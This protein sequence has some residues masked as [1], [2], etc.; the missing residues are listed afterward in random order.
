MF[1]IRPPLFIG[2]SVDHIAAKKIIG[3]AVK[4]LLGGDPKMCEASYG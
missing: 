3:L 4:T 2:G 1:T